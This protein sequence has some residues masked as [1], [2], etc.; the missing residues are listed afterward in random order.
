[1][2]KLFILLNIVIGSLYTFNAHAYQSGSAPWCL[3]DNMGN[4]TCY[5]Y[6]LDGCIDAKALSFGPTAC[7]MNPNR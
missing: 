5:Y 3:A 6:S 7:V 4:L 2:R 1:M